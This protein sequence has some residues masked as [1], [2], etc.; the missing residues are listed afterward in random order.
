MCSSIISCEDKNDDYN[1]NIKTGLKTPK[2]VIVDEHRCAIKRD[3]N[4]H[5]ISENGISRLSRKS[6]IACFDNSD[7]KMI[8]IVCANFTDENMKIIKASN[9]ENCKLINESDKK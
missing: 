1:Y 5:T 8:K 6:K 3:G 2:I 7:I 4:L 9:E